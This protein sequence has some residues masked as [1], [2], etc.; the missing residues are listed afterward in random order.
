MKITACHKDFPITIS[1]LQL[2]EKFSFWATALPSTAWLQPEGPRGSG[3]P[4]CVHCM[5]GCII[6]YD[7]SYMFQNRE[8]RTNCSICLCPLPTLQT[9]SSTSPDCNAWIQ[10]EK[11]R[12]G[13]KSR[14]LSRQERLSFS[15]RVQRV[16]TCHPL[17]RLGHMCTCPG[18]QLWSQRFAASP[19]PTVS[20]LV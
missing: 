2:L 8:P 19:S 13:V 14:Y 5:L 4:H 11:E 7:T 17:P 9:N 18:T 15:S 20:C 1:I 3:V 10:K 12:K 16:L 6:T